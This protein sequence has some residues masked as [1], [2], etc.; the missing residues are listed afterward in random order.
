MSEFLDFIIANAG[1]ITA[2][3]VF[4]IPPLR[5]FIIKKFQSSL[6]KALEDKKSLN[7]RKNYISKARFDKEFE[8][9]QILSEKQISLVYD[10]GEAVIL[11]RGEYRDISY[12]EKFSEKFCSDY[13]EADIWLKRYAPF[14][15][16][17]IFEKYKRLDNLSKDLLNLYDVRFSER[18]GKC[19]I[20][21]DVKY[22]KESAK[23]KIETMQKEISS[24]SD[25][26]IEFVREYLQSLDVIEK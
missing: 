1:W 7:D 21:N 23:V 4:C 19:F 13:N 17:E 14:I 8:L 11:T 5:D 3:I 25:N 18:D 2:I 20:F 12:C 6:D 9:Y 24:L 26:I 22:T 16:K 15:S 10:C